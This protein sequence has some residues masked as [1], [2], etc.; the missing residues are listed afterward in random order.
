MPNPELKLRPGIVYG[1]E[2][3]NHLGIDLRRI[4]RHTEG[5]VAHMATGAPGDLA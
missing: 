5:A 1:I 3:L 2:L 4:G